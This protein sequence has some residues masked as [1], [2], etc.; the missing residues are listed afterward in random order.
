MPTKLSIVP[1]YRGGGVLLLV[2]GEID[3]STASRVTA[4]VEQ[5]RNPGTP[6]I[7]DLTEVEFVDSSGARAIAQADQELEAN[8]ERLLTVPSPAV[9]RVVEIGG[10]DQ[11]L[12]LCANLDEALD[13]GR[14]FSRRPRPGRHR[15]P[16]RR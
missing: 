16:R 8:G 6:L 5:A 2:S 12:H 1:E 13:A 11:A 4:A 9:R 7:L 10:L 15:P 14:R 3:L